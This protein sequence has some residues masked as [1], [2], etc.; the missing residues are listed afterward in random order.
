MEYRYGYRLFQGN[1]KKMSIS[2]LFICAALL[3]NTQRN[4]RKTGFRI[5]YYN[6]KKVRLPRIVNM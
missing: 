5:V 6:V 4:V 1:G 2:N 3:I